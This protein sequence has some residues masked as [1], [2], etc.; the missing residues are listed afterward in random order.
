MQWYVCCRED[1]KDSVDVERGFSW[2]IDMTFASA[3]MVAEATRQ[4]RQKR[5]SARREL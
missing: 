2:L 5:E 4:A 1:T 3:R